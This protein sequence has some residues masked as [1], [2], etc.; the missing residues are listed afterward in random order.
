MSY[1]VFSCFH[2]TLMWIPDTSD[3]WKLP[4][5]GSR[6]ICVLKR[7]FWSSGTMLVVVLGGME[8]FKGARTMS[9]L[10]EVSSASHRLRK[11]VN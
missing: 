9:T 4:V 6:I 1:P 5:T 3:R 11:P 8:A 2:L 10:C 7:A